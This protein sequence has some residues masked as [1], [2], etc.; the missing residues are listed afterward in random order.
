M[1]LVSVAV[2]V[3]QHAAFIENCLEG[4]LAQ[5]MSDLEILIGEDGSTD[6]SRD[7]CQR[8]A[9]S[10]PDRIRLFLFDRSDVIHIMGR[11]TGRANTIKLY[12]AARGRYIAKCD[13]DDHWCDTRK[14]SDQIDLLEKDP[15]LSASFTNAYNRSEHHRS[16]YHPVGRIFPKGDR[17]DLSDIIKGV[18]IPTSTL[19]LRKDAMLP[20]PSELFT[21]P[22]GDVVQFIHLAR[23][24]DIGYIDRHTTVRMIHPGGIH[25]MTSDLHKWKF[26]LSMIPYYYNMCPAELHQAISKRH[27]AIL[28]NLWDLAARSKKFGLARKCWWEIR[29]QKD[30]I[31]WDVAQWRRSFVISHF[32]WII[33]LFH[34]SKKKP[35]QV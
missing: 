10:Y 5:E 20:I 17:I 9:D 34:R 25:S 3:Y 11:P 18:G 27:V 14:L 19:V 1:P 24:G 8:Y 23:Q 7:I 30:L 12:Q 28:E 35:Q 22:A 6:G 29:R 2:T 15:G 4:I 21:A 32:P 13:G 31:K 26:Q 33:P 16:S